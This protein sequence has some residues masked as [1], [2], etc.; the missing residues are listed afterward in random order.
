MPYLEKSIKDLDIAVTRKVMLSVVG[1]VL[2]HT[3]V[4]SSEDIKI[5]YLGDSNVELESGSYIDSDHN[6]PPS[7]A[8][9]SYS[10]ITIDATEEE[11]PDYI[12]SMSSI[13]NNEL[14]LIEDKKIGLEI[15]PDHSMKLVTVN[16]TYRSS[17]E[18]AVND[19]AN[20]ILRRLNKSINYMPHEIEYEL[21]LNRE[22]IALIYELYNKREAQEGYGQSFPE[23]FKEV[24]KCPHILKTTR[25]GDEYAISFERTA[26]TIYGSFDIEKR[27]E[28]KRDE[29]L[30]IY[31]TTLTYQFEYFKP[32]SL[33]AKYPL[34]VHNQTINPFWIDTNS[35][36]DATKYPGYSNEV[37]KR[38]A[39]VL[40]RNRMES[41]YEAIVQ[42][43]FDDW[44]SETKVS[45]MTLLFRTMC[46]I[47][48]D[49]TSKIVDLNNLG[50]FKLTDNYKEN[51][52]KYS[53]RVTYRAKWFVFLTAYEDDFM[54]SQEDLYLDE[55]L[56]LRSKKPLDLRKTY[57]FAI[58]TLVDY[59][60]LDE[61]TYKAMEKEPKYIYENVVS[62][63]P[64]ILERKIEL[65][66]Y[67][68]GT[69]AKTDSFIS[70]VNNMQRH[71][72][73]DTRFFNRVC[74]LSNS[75]LIKV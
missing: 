45:G 29:E 47:T 49:D 56:I 53:N 37:N 25:D 73:M 38:F 62:I 28:L 33:I 11:N 75:V 48:K 44:N 6:T 70:L 4:R 15:K 30:N 59:T 10:K 1:T 60:V 54:M 12:L 63:D 20:N 19:W 43:H 23:Y 50:K 58:Y 5:S 67:S 16:F 21:L 55:N 13:R 41:N 3:A 69:L 17:S 40:K 71:T 51:I 57:R 68:N 2:K 14:P 18:N 34:V 24:C 9:G 66:T 36:Y 74:F 7:V 42:P 61:E 27:P 64:T 32:H 52:S 8:Y 72:L 35:L 39:G 31:E 65:E 46:Q 26:A 22:Y